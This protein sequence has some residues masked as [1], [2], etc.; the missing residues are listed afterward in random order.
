M[1]TIRLRNHLEKFYI[2][3]IDLNEFVTAV[4]LPSQ[5]FTDFYEV[6]SRVFI[7]TKKS[8]E[9]G[10]IKTLIEPK[11]LVSFHSTSWNILN[12]VYKYSQVAKQWL[13]KDIVH[14]FLRES[15]V[16]RLLV[17]LEDTSVEYILKYFYFFELKG[18]IIFQRSGPY[19]SDLIWKELSA[20]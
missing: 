10:R 19:F 8:I 18:G 2:D 9:F 14:E 5:N 20:R 16:N 11:S 4:G 7:C 13:R 3:V 17:Y 1:T 12:Q 15:S 6:F